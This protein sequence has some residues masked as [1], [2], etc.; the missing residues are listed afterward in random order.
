MAVPDCFRWWVIDYKRGFF[1]FS[2][3]FVGKLN[4]DLITKEI[5]EINQK[6]L[7]LMA[8]QTIRPSIAC[9]GQS[10][11]QDLESIIQV[12]DTEQ[13]GTQRSQLRQVG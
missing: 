11:R 12:G 13:S 9:T 5:R 4:A 7:R 8:D 3:S 1:R 6:W 10:C 2:E